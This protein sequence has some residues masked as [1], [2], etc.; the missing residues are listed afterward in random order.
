[1]EETR[2]NTITVEELQKL[3]KEDPDLIAKELY[4]L[5]G[6]FVAR[7]CQIPYREVADTVQQLV[8]KA[9]TV[10]DKFDERAGFTTFIYKVFLNEVL[11]ENRKKHAQCRSSGN[12]IH[13][14]SEVTDTDEVIYMDMIP[15]LSRKDVLT[16]M[17]EEEY[18][19]I[20][21][22]ELKPITLDYF[23]GM[24]QQDLAEKYNISQPYVSRVIKK[25][26]KKLREIIKEK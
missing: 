11:M 10:L 14:D 4:L 13:L 24:K 6:Y 21:K 26:I 8:T 16:E 9:W 25:D 19:E 3:K 7:N 1:M 2:L 23:N 15:D 12:I 17:I 20:A 18:L 5:A 22:R